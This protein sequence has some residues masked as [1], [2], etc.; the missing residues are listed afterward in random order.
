MAS[1]PRKLTRTY[2]VIVLALFVFGMLLYRT[3]RTLQE[4]EVYE[5]ILDEI[6]LTSYKDNHQAIIPVVRFT[7][8]EL[9]P[10]FGIT[11]NGGDLSVFTRALAPGDK[12]KIYYDH[13][14]EFSKGEIN[15]MVVQLE[16]SGVVLLDLEDGNRQNRM[17]GYILIAASI[18]GSIL[19]F[20]YYKNS[21]CLCWSS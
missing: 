3:Q 7:M 15:H 9:K 4:F 6:A 1:S 20:V 12:I 13:Y 17:V 16:K 18:V 11:E 19:T 8:K 14:D 2:I 21:P 5:G 10:K